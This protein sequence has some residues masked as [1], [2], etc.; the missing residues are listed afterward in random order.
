VLA[1]APGRGVAEEFYYLIVF[2]VE[3]EVNLPR[4]A[5]TF[6]TFVKATGRGPCSQCYTVEARTISWLPV[7]G[8]VRVARFAPEPGVNHDLAGSLRWAANL[9]ARTTCWGPFQVRKELYDRACAQ[10][11]RLESGTVLYKTVDGE[12]W[13]RASNCIHAVSDVDADAGRLDTWTDYGEEASRL[14]VH[15][16]LRWMIDPCRTHEWVC[17]RLGLGGAAV[18]RRTWGR[19]AWR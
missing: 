7:T 8:E 2:A 3:G 14:V 16:F 19:V 10:I 11:E 18:G 6:A 1:L 5:H 13:P 17:D 9:S 12:L 15:H 4:Y